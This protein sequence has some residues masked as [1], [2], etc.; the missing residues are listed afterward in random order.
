MWMESGY[1]GIGA[2]QNL[3]ND[4]NTREISIDGKRE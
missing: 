2:K 1:Q 4:G 3:K